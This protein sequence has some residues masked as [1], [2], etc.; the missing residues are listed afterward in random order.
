LL[1]RFPLSL[2]AFAAL[3]IP[4][5]A[6]PERVITIKMIDARTGQ[7]VRTTDF[8]IQ[9]NH[10]EAL[11][12][13]WVRQNTSGAGEVTVP[14]D[15]TEILIRGKYDNNMEIYINCDTEAERKTAHGA[16]IPDH[17]YSISQILVSGLVAPDGCK[18]K[19]VAKH[20]FIAKPGEFIFFVRKL[21]W[22]EQ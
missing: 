18:S 10:L 19:E 16:E 15:A 14:P 17:W 3:A 9:V 12:A 22:R 20:D 6:Q 11:H 1:R 13:D 7:M 5:L 8:L 21:N 2:I 4:A